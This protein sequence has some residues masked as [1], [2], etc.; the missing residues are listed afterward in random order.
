M[1]ATVNDHGLEVG[2]EEAAG[3]CRAE[4]VEELAVASDKSND[5]PKGPPLPWIGGLRN[6]RV[7]PMVVINDGGYLVPLCS[8]GDLV[9]GC[10]LF[11]R[12]S[13]D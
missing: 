10:R 1:T 12:I 3:E 6:P 8:A 11:W 7:G 13:Q 9:R 5:S 4:V 2:D